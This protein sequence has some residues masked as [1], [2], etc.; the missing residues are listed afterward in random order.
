ME[1]N[2][3]IFDN[4]LEGCQIISHDWR[5]LYVNDAAAKQSRVKRENL[6]GR[7][8]MGVYH[9]IEKTELFSNLQKSMKERVPVSMENEFTFHDGDKSW[10]ELKIE[11]VPEGIFVLS[12]D[13][14][15]HKKAEEKKRVI[16]ES[17]AENYIELDNEWRYNDINERIEKALGKKK[18]ELI[19]KH[20]YDV[21]PILRGS[22]LYEKVKEAKEKNKPLDFEV[23]IPMSGRCVRVYVYP[24]DDGIT[25]YSHDITE[26][27]MAEEAII[28]SEERY[29]SLFKNN[30]AVML[31]IDPD[32]GDI[33]DA[34]PAACSFY[35]YSKTELLKMKIADINILKDEQVFEEM[36]KA[37]SEKKNHF[38]F[39][40]ILASG[41]IRDVDVYSGSIIVN[42]KVLLYSIVHDVTK[43]IEAE[44]ELKRRGK[45]VEG[46]NRVL[47]GSL[48]IETEENVAGKCL[49]V[50]EDLTGSKFGFLGEISPDGYLNTL[51]ISPIAWKVFKI[52]SEK[53][54]PVK[55][56]E[57]VS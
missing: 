36:Q 43:Q 46:I 3:S 32:T 39:K 37:R 8:V 9:G 22:K 45:V 26:R 48:I 20:P 57:I 56:M 21:F 42:G 7:K 49:E 30:H 17:M 41:D 14:T 24:S 54:G 38:I 51:A 28:E 1:K 12:I 33:V 50:A 6:L 18:E 40:H 13:I 25:I 19:G 2:Y 10:F 29:H 53:L 52:S 55:K 5:Y 11:P 16:L 44:K 34:N 47:H 4:M 27:K 15:K 31:L 35:G 23:R